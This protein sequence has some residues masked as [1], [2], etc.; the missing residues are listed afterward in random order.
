MACTNQRCLVIQA[1]VQL[2]CFHYQL[3]SYYPNCC[4]TKINCGYTIYTHV[5]PLISMAAG[6]CVNTE[7]L[8]V[9]STYLDGPIYVHW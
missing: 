9:D 4:I 1:V 3:C 5:A 7:W 2:L 6:L 8:E